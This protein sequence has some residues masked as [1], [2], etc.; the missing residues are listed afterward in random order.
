MSHR[1]ATT[2][3]TLMKIAKTICDALPLNTNTSSPVMQSLLAASNT[4][5]HQYAG[6]YMSQRK[7]VLSRLSSASL[8]LSLSS[9]FLFLKSRLQ[10][11][12]GM[13]SG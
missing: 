1:K 7:A 8:I 2:E 9:F 11:S 10:Y 5:N 12:N 3:H 13:P 4:S 6:S